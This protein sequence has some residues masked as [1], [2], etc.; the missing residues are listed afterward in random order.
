MNSSYPYVLYYMSI[1]HEKWMRFATPCNKRNLN[2]TAHTLCSFINNSIFC[3]PHK[4]NIWLVHALLLLNTFS[5]LNLG[6]SIPGNCSLLHALLYPQ[7]MRHI[8]PWPN[9][10]KYSIQWT[11]YRANLHQKKHSVRD[12]TSDGAIEHRFIICEFWQSTINILSTLTAKIAAMKTRVQ[13]YFLGGAETKALPS[14]LSILTHIPIREYNVCLVGIWNLVMV[15]SC[16]LKRIPQLR[17]L[18]GAGRC[19]LVGLSNVYLQDLERLP[20]CRLK[21][22]AK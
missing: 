4:A 8:I 6:E 2:E 17:N 7:A 5:L 20:T 13:L 18:Q 1:I 21:G 3:N 16:F 22:L 15:Y 10:A 14:K 12:F 9:Y 11:A 19:S